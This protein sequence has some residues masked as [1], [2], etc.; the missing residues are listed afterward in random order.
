MAVL[1]PARHFPFCPDADEA[2]QRHQ[3]EEDQQEQADAPCKFSGDSGLMAKQCAQHPAI[4]NSRRGKLEA[5][6]AISYFAYRRSGNLL[7]QY[8]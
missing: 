1:Q 7:N 8:Q 3:G 4:D 2:D 5:V 6:H